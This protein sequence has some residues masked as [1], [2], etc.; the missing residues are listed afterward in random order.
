[1][2]DIADFSSRAHIN[3][4]SSTLA[5]FDRDPSCCEFFTADNCSVNTATATMANVPLIGCASHRL[6]L[7]TREVIKQG[8]YQPMINDNLIIVVGQIKS[9]LHIIKL[10]IEHIK[11]STCK[12]IMVE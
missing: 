8:G 6:A 5:W 10:I 9:R 11:S 1:M 2:D 7:A 3:F 12:I 4:I